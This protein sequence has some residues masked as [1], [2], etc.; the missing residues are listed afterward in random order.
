MVR[1]RARYE[2]V[3]NIKSIFTVNFREPNEIMEVIETFRGSEVMEG[4]LAKLFCRMKHFLKGY[5]FEKADQKEIISFAAEAIDGDEN[6]KDIIGSVSTMVEKLKPADEEVNSKLIR[7]LLTFLLSLPASEQVEAY[8]VLGDK[9]N[10]A[11]FKQT[12][13]ENDIQKIDLQKLLQTSS[14]DP[15]ENADP[16]LK[17]FIRAAV[18][19]NER[20]ENENKNCRTTI[21]TEPPYL[22]QNCIKCREDYSRITPSILSGKGKIGG[23]RWLT[24][25]K[26]YLVQLEGISW[27]FQ[28]LSVK[29]Y[30]K[31]ECV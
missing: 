23:R 26:K 28:R 1:K 20:F 15:F 17:A 7:S 10:D 8:E 11:L 24:I 4:H 25:F 30:N 3:G 2:N 27:K 5:D 31:Y 13:E 12:K 19:T 16:R 18:K 22:P 6:E 29:R 9:L 14:T 21:E